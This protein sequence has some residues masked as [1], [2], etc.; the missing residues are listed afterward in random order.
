[1]HGEAIDGFHQTSTNRFEK[2][3]TEMMYDFKLIWSSEY[4]SILD[5]VK[6]LT[7]FTTYHFEAE[8]T[9]KIYDFEI[10]L[11]KIQHLG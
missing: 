4:H 1:M 5:K 6:L 10:R 7:D 8:I 3:K 2:G 11:V 9:E